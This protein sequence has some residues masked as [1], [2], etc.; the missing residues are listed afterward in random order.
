MVGGAEWECSERGGGGGGVGMDESDCGLGGIV[1][2]TGSVA[3]A[4]CDV[5]SCDFAMIISINLSLV[6]HILLRPISRPRFCSSVLVKFLFRKS[7]VGLLRDGVFS[8][9]STRLVSL[10]LIFELVDGLI[11]W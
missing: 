8:L 4:V 11:G 2:I 5:G 7:Q 6:T 9:S 1:E 10:L 3:S